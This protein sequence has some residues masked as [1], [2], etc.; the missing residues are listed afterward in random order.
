M[1]TIETTASA[2]RLLVRTRT[3]GIFKRGNG[4]VVRF[5]DLSGKQRQRAARTLVEARRLRLELGADVSRGEY[6]PDIKITFAAYAERWRESYAGR[7]ARGLR[8]E[9][10][11]EYARDLGPAVERLGRMRLAEITPAD[12]KDYARALEAQG[13]RPAT[14]AGDWHP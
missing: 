6:R 9:T 7:T 10:R 11:A 5:R 4:Y 1:G 12:V 2:G 8:P 3:P 13:L 14:C